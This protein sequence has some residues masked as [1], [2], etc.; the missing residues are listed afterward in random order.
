M[1]P[2]VM[3]TIDREFKSVFITGPES[4]MV[5]KKG[6]SGAGAALARRW[7]DGTASRG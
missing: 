6:E 3:R 5:K 7:I 1:A 4:G 2:L